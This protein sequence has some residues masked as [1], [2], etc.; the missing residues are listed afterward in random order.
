MELGNPGERGVL[1]PEANEKVKAAVGDA[2][3]LL[4]AGMQRKAAPKL[5]EMSQM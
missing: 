5:P 2:D 4:P 3:K 1:V